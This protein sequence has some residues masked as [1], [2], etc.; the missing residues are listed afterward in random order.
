M[1]MKCQSCGVNGCFDHQMEAFNEG[2]DFPP[3]SAVTTCGKCSSARLILKECAKEAESPPADKEVDRPPVDEDLA[4]QE[5]NDDFN[6]GPATLSE[7]QRLALSRLEKYGKDL[8]YEI[9]ALVPE[10]K[11]RTV[12]INNVLGAILWARHGIVSSG[13]VELVSVTPSE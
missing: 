10:G 1:V 11:Y 7:G 8:A 9:T 6:F 2:W 13:E 3:F 4:V 5:V 12:A